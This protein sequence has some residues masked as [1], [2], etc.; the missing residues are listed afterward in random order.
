MTLLFYADREGTARMGQ[1]NHWHRNHILELLSISMST[2]RC[3]YKSVTKATKHY[4]LRLTTLPT[5]SFFFKHHT[6]SSAGP[7]RAQQSK[8]LDTKQDLDPIDLE[9][10]SVSSTLSDSESPPT[11][12]EAIGG[13]IAGRS[14][15]PAT[16]SFAP[17]TQLQIHATGVTSSSSLCSQDPLPIPV[18]RIDPGTSTSSIESTE[19]EYI[20]LRL[21]KKSN[22]CALVRGSDPSRRPLNATIYRWGP[23]KPPKIRIL[24]LDSSASVEEAINS[25]NLESDLLEVRSRSIIS[26]SQKIATSFGTFQW[27]YGGRSEKKDAFDANSLLILEKID[28]LSAKKSK[29]QGIRVAQFI[30][31]DE[32]RTPGTNKYMAGNGGRLMLDLRAWTGEK[33]TDTA[34][35]E[36]F[37]IASCICMLK[38]EVDRMR[39]NTTAAIV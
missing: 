17:T 1:D 3:F 6:R 8:Q 28:G 18:F 23:G 5:M 35:I 31:N 11:Y 22:S 2:S 9:T 30:R 27:R 19:P 38:R 10:A 37:M 21:K 29:K 12:S 39:D 33:E 34:K 26:R 15:S 32:F 4:K 14:V 16:A 24:P 36:A 7:G 13:D 20:S 25:E